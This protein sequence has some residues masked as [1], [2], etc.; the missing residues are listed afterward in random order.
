MED[1]YKLLV[2]ETDF[3]LE[4]CR[5]IPRDKLFKDAILRGSI[6]ESIDRIIGFLRV[7]E[8]RDGRRIDPG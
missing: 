8:E 6:N 7:M 4:R 5:E 1:I 2:D 3:I